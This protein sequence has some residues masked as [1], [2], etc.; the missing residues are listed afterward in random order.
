MNLHPISR[1]SFIFV[2]ALC[3]T[4]GCAVSPNP[5][6]EVAAD[7]LSAAQ[8]SAK[9][10]AEVLKRAQKIN[11]TA[12]IAT[13]N[14]FKGVK[15]IYGNDLSGKL[16]LVRI[17]DEVERS[18]YLVLESYLAKK[19]E[20]KI[21]KVFVAA[22]GRVPESEKLTVGGIGKA[23]KA[24]LEA[25]VL[26]K[27]RKVSED[28]SVQGMKLLFGGDAIFG[29]TVVVRVSDETDP[30]DYIASFSMNGDADQ[31]AGTCKVDFAEISAD[32]LLPPVAGL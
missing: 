28:A 3:T 8:C 30:S 29:G 24:S 31:K 20:C 11:D 13:D 19:G 17:T 5:E 21:G 27:A 18:D 16:T 2:A 22:D 15:T 12:S 32:G 26:K 7:A 4:V 6:G 9:I 14:A 25:A 23:C 10:Q 1:I